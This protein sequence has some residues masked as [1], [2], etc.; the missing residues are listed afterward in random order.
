[1]NATL[2]H[3]AFFFC[4]I[5]TDINTL[6]NFR[7]HFLTPQ[8]AVN[9]SKSISNSTIRLAGGRF[10]NPWLTISWTEVQEHGKEVA[11]KVDLKIFRMKNKT[12]LNEVRGLFKKYPD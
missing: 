5:V 11:G 4:A 8:S 2:G 1:M 7:P 3:V 12:V 10:G 6:T 9:V